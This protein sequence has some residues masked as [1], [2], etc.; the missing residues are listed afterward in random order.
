MVDENPTHDLG[1]KGQEMRTVL[2]ADSPGAHEL[3]VRLVGQRRRVDALAGVT[4]GEVAAR[5]PPQRRVDEIHQ[6]VERSRLAFG[7]GG[8]HPR[9]VVRVLVRHVRSSVPEE[10]P[11]VNRS[12]G[13]SRSTGR[14]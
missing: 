7:P 13:L 12:R 1:A 9:D 5:D 10:W 11:T 6:A 2:A 8:E 4:A 14:R 3:Q